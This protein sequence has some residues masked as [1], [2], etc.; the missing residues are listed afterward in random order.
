MLFKRESRNELES[1]ICERI[2]LVLIYAKVM[3]DIIG[4]REVVRPCAAGPV[5]IKLNDG[6]NRRPTEKSNNAE[7]AMVLEQSSYVHSKEFAETCV[8]SEP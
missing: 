7:K 1:L 8:L 4:D 6:G 3:E 2:G 5:I